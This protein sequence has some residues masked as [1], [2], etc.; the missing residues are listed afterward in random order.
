[1]GLRHRLPKFLKKEKHFYEFKFRHVNTKTLAIHIR[2]TPK[3]SPQ[4][5]QI[6]LK[7]DV[8]VHTINTAERI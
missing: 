8:T 3:P 4:H 6:A 1:M 5:L 7:A 2:I